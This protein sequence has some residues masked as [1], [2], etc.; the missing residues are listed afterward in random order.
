MDSVGPL[1]CGVGG[2]RPGRPQRSRGRI[3]AG[4][5]PTCGAGSL[6]LTPAGPKRHRRLSVK[7]VIS[8]RWNHRQTRLVRIKL[9]RVPAR[10]ALAISCRGRGCPA[11][12]PHASSATLRRRRRTLQ[13]KLDRA[14]DRLLLS[15]SAPS[16]RPERARITIRD[17]RPPAVRLL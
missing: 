11:H 2:H 16:W 5:G 9:G 7:I 12:K 6:A 4:P 10:A 14:G 3:G 1:G 15:L 8:W 13:G 17:G